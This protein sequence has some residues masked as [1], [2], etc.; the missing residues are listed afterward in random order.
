MMSVMTSVNVF[1]NMCVSEHVQQ[2]IAY[3][4][5]RVVCKYAE[6][7][8]VTFWPLHHVL[9]HL[10]HAHIVPNI[11]LMSVDMMSVM[12]SMNV[13]GNTCMSGH[14]K[15][16]IACLKCTAVCRCAKP[17][18]VMSWPFHHVISHPGHVQQQLDMDLISLSHNVLYVQTNMEYSL[19]QA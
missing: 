13:C 14:V 15:Q 5:C 6:L 3:L 7:W 1:G 19:H 10:G 2:D 18:D 4:A 9:T 8:D 17:W 16:D 12:T 11:C